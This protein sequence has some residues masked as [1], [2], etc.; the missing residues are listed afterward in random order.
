MPNAVTFSDDLAV[1]CRALQLAEQ[2][3]GRVEPNPPVG[4]VLVDEHRQLISEGFHEHF[5]GPHAEVLAL[6]GVQGH[7]L[8]RATLFVTLEPCQHTG[9]T[10]PCTEAIVRSGLRRVVVATQDPAPHTRGAGIAALREHGVHVEVGLLDDD[11]RELIAPFKKLVKT[12][13]PYVHAKWAMTLDGKLATRERDS[14]W[15]SGEESRREVHQLRGRVD[16]ILVG[17]GTALSDDPLLTARPPGPRIATR[18]V[19]DRR[20]RLPI[21]SQLVSTAHDVPLLVAV[22]RDAPD[23]RRQ[24][25][26]SHGAEIL[27]LPQEDLAGDHARRVD[28]RAL[29][30]ELGHR[31][32]T[33]LLVE[34]GSDVFGSFVDRQLVD[35]FHIFVGPVIVGGSDAVTAV[36]GGGGPSMAEGLRLK[37][38]V[39]ERLGED[40]YIR[41]LAAWEAQDK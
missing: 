7:D 15:I 2:G 3:R 13:L 11:A 10:P 4:A 27:V 1:M 29:L 12:G 16:A 6:A 23:A 28:L 19:L 39:V 17:I 20:A 34:G 8:Q 32:M 36:G 18:I 37:R 14:R 5:G 35:V 26:E 31:R 30:T 38:T 9:K 22:G 33:N 40:V 24:S 21:E 41:G 25:L